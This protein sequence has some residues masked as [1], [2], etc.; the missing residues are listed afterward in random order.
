MI[1]KLRDYIVL[2]GVAGGVVALDQWTKF[3][4]RTRLTVGEWWMPVTWLSSFARI[5]HWNNTGA[6]FGMFPSG[7][8]I[9]TL[10]AVV[11]AIAILYYYPRVPRKQ[12]ALR[13]ALAL[14]LGGAVGNLLDRLTQGT[15]TDFISVGNFPV[16]NLADASISLGV[17][18]LVVTMMIDERRSKSEAMDGE[19]SE[20]AERSGE[21]ASEVERTA[22]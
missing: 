1:S 4:V 10:I 12:V 22:G 18:V 14:Q 2:F 8:L 3:L 20:R 9:F 16:F 15:V 7:S 6:A 11:V 5:V 21:G 17:A 19:P 13:F